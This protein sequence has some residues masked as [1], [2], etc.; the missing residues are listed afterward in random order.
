MIFVL[1]SH[2]LCLMAC[3]GILFRNTFTPKVAQQKFSVNLC[4]LF[5]YLIVK[6]NITSERNSR[7]EC[8]VSP[9]PRAHGSESQHGTCFAK[10]ARK[11]DYFYYHFYSW[12]HEQSYSF[13]CCTDINECRISS[14]V[15]GNGT[16]ENTP[17]GFSCDCYPGYES[18]F[19]TRVCTGLSWHFLCCC[20]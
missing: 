6:I 7:I 9:L 5:A 11:Y 14:N 16:C 2:F 12:H 1:I 4:K 3:L 17:G 15:C 13:I 19:S 8:D 20:T 10:F 18:T